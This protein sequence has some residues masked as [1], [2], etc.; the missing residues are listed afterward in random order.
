MGEDIDLKDLIFSEGINEVIVSTCKN[1]APMGIIRKHNNLSMIVFKTSHTASHIIR[2]GWI[3]AHICHDP[4]MFVKTAFEDLSEESYIRESFQGMMIDRI[5]EIQDYIVCRARVVN[6]TPE[7][8]YV[9]VTPVHFQVTPAYPVPVHRGLNNIIEATVHATR[10]IL[11]NDPKLAD[12][13]RHHGELILRCG[14]ER[15]KAALN[16]LFQYI[17]KNSKPFEKV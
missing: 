17:N 5:K 14:G 4:L 10:Y 12:L 9:E 6:T 13:I 11:N 7:T 3:V 16:L 1:A 8:I 15:D 2:D